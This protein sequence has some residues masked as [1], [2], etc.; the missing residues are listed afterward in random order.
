MAKRDCKSLMFQGTGSDV[1]KTVLVAGLCRLARNRGMIVRPFKA[2]NMSNNAAVAEIPLPDGSYGE[3]GRA[4]WLQALACGV[5]SSVDMNPILL[6]PQSEIGSQ[7]IVHGKVEDNVRA[8][9][10]QA[11]KPRLLS[12]VME[13]YHRLQESSDLVLVEGA[14]SC[15]E[16][17]LRAG[18]IANMGFA[19]SADIPVVLIADI[20]RGGVIASIVGTHCLLPCDERTRIR[21]FI[22]NKFRGDSSLF[23]PA[24][25]EI[26]TRTQWDCLGIVPWLS[27]AFLLPAEDSVILDRLSLRSDGRSRSNSQDKFKIVV[28]VL[29]RI[30]NFDDL[31]PLLHDSSLDVH[32][33]SPHEEW[34]SD[35]SLV[36]LTGSKSTIADLAEFQNSGGAS[37]LSAHIDR[38][39]YVLGIC[40]GYQMLGKVISDPHGI[41]G[42]AGD[43]AGLGYLDITTH[44][45][46]E[47]NVGLTSAVDTTFNLPLS[48]YEIHMG[49]TTGPDTS[50]PMLRFP[51]RPDGAISVD[52]RIC[53]CYLHGLFSNDNWRC[54]YLASLGISSQNQSFTEVVDNALDTI[55]SELSDIFPPSFFDID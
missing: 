45:G 36:I 20:D 54:A 6:K 13:S 51:T 46:G 55:A 30:S 1:G 37:R 19:T 24:I 35:T 23:S 42:I 33:A 44:L 31:D 27:D 43:V 9:D 38:G 34:D 22:I 21:G 40:G 2:Q 18:D 17:N 39:G 48:G 50:R 49:E 32:F 15:A 3:I 53:G 25:D 47:K 29:S 26:R 11:L 7:L 4:Q 41:E 14:G 16:V 52:G 28:P 5:P 12:S 10:Y 8:R